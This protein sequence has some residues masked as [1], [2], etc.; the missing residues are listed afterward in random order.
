MKTHD[1]LENK[2]RILNGDN[3]TLKSIL[4][5]LRDDDNSIIFKYHLKMNVID[6]LKTKIKLNY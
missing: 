4:K 6:I 3:E 1:L 2:E 5:T